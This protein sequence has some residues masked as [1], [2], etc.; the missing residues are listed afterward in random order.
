MRTPDLSTEKI[1]AFQ[2]LCNVSSSVSPLSLTLYSMLQGSIFYSA[3]CEKLVWKVCVDKIYKWCKLC[4][5]FHVIHISVCLATCPDPYYWDISPYCSTTIF[6][7]VHK[8]IG[9]FK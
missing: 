7:K 6:S 4:K 5:C 8:G 2:Q 9:A 3:L 1:N